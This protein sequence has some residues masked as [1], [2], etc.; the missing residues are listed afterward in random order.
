MLYPLSYE[1]NE[2]GPCADCCANYANRPHL[3][4]LRLAG[5]C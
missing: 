5:R 3:G 2:G 4:V 1:G